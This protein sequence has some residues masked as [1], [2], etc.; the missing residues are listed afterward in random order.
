MTWRVPKVFM[1][2]PRV[3]VR[4]ERARSRGHKVEIDPRPPRRTI[5]VGYGGSKG[6]GRAR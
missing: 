1:N 4:V 2:D 6:K 3:A 5:I